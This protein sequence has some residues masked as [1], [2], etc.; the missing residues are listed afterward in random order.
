MVVLAALFAAGNSPADVPGEG[1]P[2]ATVNR[3]GETLVVDVDL[4]VGVSPRVAWEVLTDFPHMPDF[5]PGVESSDSQLQSEGIYF[6]RQTGRARYGPFSRS[7]DS[8]RLIELHPYHRIDSRGLTGDLSTLR[9]S[10]V[11]TPVGTGVHLHY[12]AE[13][14][15]GT[16]LPPVIGTAAVRHDTETRFTAF[17]DEMRRRAAVAR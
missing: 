15:P 2:T 10:M 1:V 12:H 6:V 16:W 5:L 8:S 13:A 14:E 3:R 4:T 11:L 17:V 9:G 7:Y